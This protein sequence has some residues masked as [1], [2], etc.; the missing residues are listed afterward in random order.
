METGSLISRQRQKLA[1]TAI[2]QGSTHILWLDSD[3]LFPLNVVDVLLSHNQDVVA[4]NYPTR[5][6]PIKGVA[7]TKIGEWDSW[8]GFDVTNERLK[9]VEGV[10]MGCMLAKTSV[11]ERMER[12]WFEVTYSE[13]YN[14]H[15]GEDFYFCQKARSLGYQIMIDTLLSREIKHLGTTAFDLSRTQ[16]ITDK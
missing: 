13:K 11:M 3:M 7:Y 4:C 14:D 16:K 9:S 8:L 5:T 10:G 15:I 6:L 2:S 1:E 12:P